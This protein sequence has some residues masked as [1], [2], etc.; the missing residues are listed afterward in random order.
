MKTGFAQL[1]QSVVSR[2]F[3][4]KAFEHFK[5]IKE[6]KVYQNALWYL[7]FGTWCDQ[8]SDNLLLCRD[9]LAA[10]KGQKPANFVSEDFLRELEQNVLG[11][12]NLCWSEWR[13]KHCRQ[14]VKLKLGEFA[15]ILN[16]E[17]AGRWDKSGLI[18]LDGDSWSSTKA[19]HA[20]KT[21][22]ALAER[23][24]PDCTHAEFIQ[25]YLNGLPRNRFTKIINKNYQKAFSFAVRSLQGEK[26]QRELRILR[27]ILLQ[28]QPFYS[29]SSNG[30]TARLFTK[31]HVPDLKREVRQV[32]TAGWFE[33][34]LRASQLSI[35][36]R[37]WR[38]EPLMRFLSEGKNIWNYLF[39]FFDLPEISRPM[40]K[41]IFKKALYAICYGME[42]RH[43]PWCIND[44][45]GGTELGPI[46]AS[47][48]LKIPL[49][50]DLLI[51]RS[52]ELKKVAEAGG[53]TDSYGKWINVADEIQPRDILA[54]IAQSWEMKLIYPAFEIAGKTE[55]FK[56]MLFQH[57]GFSVFFRPE[58]ERWRERIKEVVDNNAKKLRIPTLLEWDKDKA[59]GANERTAIK[60]LSSY[61]MCTS[62]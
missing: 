13:K 46:I 54:R 19:R 10:I 55:D 20:R 26:L 25:R 40:A 60:Y 34:D 6:N 31:G 35:C 17:Y 30:N 5:A 23:V 22:R 44:C 3:Y 47:R 15:E 53:A 24:V 48:F 59:A 41:D 45:A 58:K 50:E 56:I 39:S 21:E 4:E 1:G 28:P 7:F 62:K 61:E 43:L 9:T 8:E 33:A 52:F 37:L 18:F 51:T 38:I 29:A 2:H 16:G 11:E 36:A 14:L 57:D 27:R 12:G 32:L 42:E 49:I